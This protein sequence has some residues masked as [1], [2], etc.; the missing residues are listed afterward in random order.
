MYDKPTKY[1]GKNYDFNSLNDR[2]FEELLHHVF[3]DRIKDDLKGKYDNAS[4]MSGVAEEGRDIILT[5]K[6]KK[7]GVIQCKK[8]NKNL[9]RPTVAKE[10]IKFVLYYYKNNT[11]IDNLESFTYYLI[12]SHKFANTSIDLLTDFKV[13]IF[14]EKDLK[15]W[16]EL[17][18]SDRN[19]KSLNDLEYSEIETKFKTILANLNVK[20]KSYSEINAWLHKYPNI[21]N[22]F[23][24]VQ[25][26]V[27]NNAIERVE[28]IL[29]PDL[30]KN[31][32][33]LIT[34]YYKVAKKHLDVVKFIGHAVS[35]NL[36]RPRNITT[37]KLYVEPFLSIEEK[38]TNKKKTVEKLLDKKKKI[39]KMH[40]VFKRSKHYVILGDPGA[41]KSLMVKHLILRF[42]KGNAKTGGLK[43]YQS[44]IPFRIELRKYNKD[45]LRSN[46][47]IVEYLLDILKKEYQLND[48]DLKTLNYILDNK[49]TLFFFD[50]LDEV[51]DT[52]QR[53]AICED[54][55]N[56]ISH[57]KNIKCLVTSRF[58]GYEDSFFP[59]DMFDTFGIE[60]FN[61]KQIDDFVKKFY[62]V[63][64]S[65]TYERRLEIES[66]KRQ[67]IGVDTNLKSN[68]LI[69][70]LMSLLAI[71]KII[72]P[73]S[74]LE[75]YRS[76]TNTLVETRDKD[77]KGL[78]FN[79]RIK[80]VRGCF[81][82]LAYWQYCNM[83]EENQVSKKLAEKTVSDYLVN[84]QKIADSLEAEDIAQEFLEYA[85]KRSI[86][87]D[88]NFMHK[89]FLEY[90]TADYI[91]T[92]Y[93][94]TSKL[95]DRD[96]I[97][98]QYIGNA[99]WHVIFEL[100][101][102]MIDEQI[103]ESEPL[104]K[105]IE[106]QLAQHENILEKN[107]FFLDI[108]SKVKHI[109]DDIKERIIDS[110]STLI[111]KNQHNSLFEVFKRNAQIEILKPLVKK[112]I[113]NI[114]NTLQGEIDLI[115]FYN[116]IYE[117]NSGSLLSMQPYQYS[118]QN[119]NK[120]KELIA[121]DANLF[122]SFYLSDDKKFIDKY[123]LVEN[124]KYFGIEN[125]FKHIDLVYEG[126]SWI[127]LFSIYLRDLE[128]D[129]IEKISN[130]LDY[131][132]ENGGLSLNIISELYTTSF[133]SFIFESKNKKLHKALS[134]YI[135]SK[136]AK[137]DKFMEVVFRG[138]NKRELKEI[139]SEF[140]GNEKYQRLINNLK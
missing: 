102:S 138:I 27:D 46:I 36:T 52:T 116:F 30:E 61:E 60:K 56:F 91:Y 75:V 15:K 38:E 109:G 55:I 5:L 39:F 14:K 51:F 34:N 104:D 114:E 136:N 98:Q 3:M 90:Y 9:D 122:N 110:S 65:N 7:N 72:I 134:L 108:L 19:N 29:S 125:I 107:Y 23:F 63:Q 128:F 120:V 26:V 13:N 33:K 137:F 83:T 11:L 94:N 121:H 97:I 2:R 79:L 18:I 48:V 25:K 54:I 123:V 53:S 64:V 81:G 127:D 85:E 69:L 106:K 59:E 58:V 115:K 8:S 88:D 1:S 129:T 105:L 57:N 73:D 140:I 87:F 80:S 99:Q 113:S 119:K 17:V 40:D 22:G 103:V 42:M 132:L 126:G 117:L 130:E 76:C 24:E 31:A 45:K 43:N 133:I 112:K 74:K 78:E 100:L 35:S 68:P 62:S 111:I 135:E 71:N 118:V 93:H 95:N 41:G 4:L 6:G 92:R 50:G 86:Y 37:S 66:C 67:L 47:N 44:Y 131:L 70:S 96:S 124:I 101:M 10:I 77:E 20:S 89:T 28:K 49:Y 32:K 84:N 12:C 139:E 82:K 16:T 21:K